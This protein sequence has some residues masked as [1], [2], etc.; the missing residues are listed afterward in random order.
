M[1][2]THL[3]SCGDSCENGWSVS[4]SQATIHKAASK[5]LKAIKEELPEE[6][7]CRAVIEEVLSEAGSIMD[8]TQLKI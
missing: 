5:A 3:F 6:A 2:A 7:Q 1:S 8:V 4:V